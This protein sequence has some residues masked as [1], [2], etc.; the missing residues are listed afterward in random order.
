LC[1]AIAV[2]ADKLEARETDG[3]T[4]GKDLHSVDGIDNRDRTYVPEID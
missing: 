4:D 3:K 2:S 1:A